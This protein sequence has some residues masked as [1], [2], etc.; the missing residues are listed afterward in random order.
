MGAYHA[1]ILVDLVALSLGVGIIFVALLSWERSGIRWLRDLAFVLLAGSMLLMLDLL[2][3]YEI[4]AGWPPGPEARVVLAVLSGAGNLMLVLAIPLFVGGIT[5]LPP[6]LVRRVLRPIGTVVIPLLGV[7]DEVFEVTLLHIM[8]DLAIA[9]LLVSA[10][11]IMAIGY[12]RIA[13][14]QTRQMVRQ[15][16]WLTIASIVLSRGQLVVTNLLGIALELRRV[17]MMQVLYY[18]AMLAVVF[19]YAVKYLFRPGGSAD[20]VLSPEFAER[21][22]ISNRERDIIAMIVQGHTNRIIGERL[23]I[24]DRTVKNHISSIYRKTGASNKVQLLNMVRNHP[25]S[26]GGPGAPVS[27]QAASGGSAPQIRA[28]SKT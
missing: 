19:K 26:R 1:M 25:G 27:G 21:Y 16:L 17:R 10:A 18:L 24:S 23:F 3:L 11:I 13:E 4:T 6:G 5:P 7:L 28:R 14:P 8:N 9:G 12:R 20:L 22:G 2:R 15:M